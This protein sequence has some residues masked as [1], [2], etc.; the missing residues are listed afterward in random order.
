MTVTESAE[1]AEAAGLPTVGWIGLGQMGH[2]MAYHVA[3][4]GH[5]MIVADAA[6]TDLAPRGARIA[7]RNGEVGVQA[8]V[9]VLSVP[10][11]AASLAV[12][13]DLIAARPRSVDLVIDTS[14]VGMRAARDAAALLEADGVA[15]VDAPVSGGVAGAEAASLSVIL[16]CSHAL[17]AR[18]SP[19]LSC[20]GGHL[21]H[22]GLEPGMGQAVKL[23]NN[24]L[25]ATAMAATSEAMAFGTAVGLDM[26]T[27]LD[28]VN[29]STG[30][31][32]ASRDKF[33]KR[34]VTES[35]DGGFAAAMMA[36]DV[37]LYLE[38]VKNAGSAA[39]LAA[40]IEAL[41]SAF[42]ASADGADF[43]RIYPFV[44]ERP[45]PT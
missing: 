44:K 31:N 5:P 37:R 41:W 4:A 13:N 15:Y 14:T 45:K 39:G 23:L 19:L 22:V 24:F 7:G 17:F 2:R 25:S 9:V 29:R 21:F 20:I 6:S 32:T 16:G 12:C 10:D 11:G 40:E 1:G 27:M 42:D 18:A 38:E 43:T 34:V 28:V 30:Q 8:S 36:K 33:P 35:Y 26:Q 3:R